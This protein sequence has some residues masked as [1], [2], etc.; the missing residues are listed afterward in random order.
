MSRIGD[1]A[2]NVMRR[3]P[4]GLSRRF[5]RPA[6]LTFHGVERTTDDA[7]V[8]TNHHEAEVFYEI[9]KALK[10]NFDILPLKMLGHVL[11]EPNRYARG[12]FLMSDDGYAN[13]LTL[14]GD[15]LKQLGLPWALFVSTH[16]IETRERNPMFLARLFFAFAPDGRYPIP[17]FEKPVVLSR[18]RDAVTERSLAHLKALPQ[19]EA[20]EAVRAMLGHVASDVDALVARFRSEMFLTW[21]DVVALYRRGVEI[22]AHAHVHWAMHARQS[23][24][25]LR[26]QAE[27]PRKLIAS[28]IG[29]C[30]FFAYP[31]GNVGDV[32]GEAWRAVRDAGY[33]YAFTTLS[34]SLDT[35]MNPFLLPRY[36]IGPRETDVAR[37]VPLLRAGNPRVR[38]FQRALSK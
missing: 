19:G 25:F 17:H 6:A 4:E 8:Q 1:I 28:H 34:G 33:E 38:R 5:A 3:L 2:R 29:E 23:R 18:V 32:S 16:H 26:E 20:C 14:A 31:F 37:V 13:T 35:N 22:G 27:R 21:D 24:S 10:Q 15:I 12:I 36:T 9:A 30:R 7:R 11:N